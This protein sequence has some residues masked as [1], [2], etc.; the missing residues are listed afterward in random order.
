MNYNPLAPAVQDNP[1]PYYAELRD[2][3][4]VAWIESM[5]AWAVSR[6]ADV[7]FILR[8]PRLFSS[9][10][11]KT[12]SSGN[13]DVAPK[14][15]SLL[16]MDPPDHTRLRKL[17][18]KGFTPRL[19]RAMEPRVRAITQDLLETLTK[20]AEADL[21]PMLSVPLPII[22]IA[23]MLGVE[24]ERQADFKHWSDA[25]VRSLNRPTDKAIRAEIRQSMSE[26]HTYLGNMITRRRT[27]PSDDLITAFVQ[28]EEERQVLT[29][30]EILGLTVLLLAAGNETTTNLI[31]N[32]ALALLDHP[33]ELAKVRAEPASVPAMVEEVLR[34]DSPVQVVF[35]QTTQE[36]E[37]DGGTLPAGATILVLLGAANRDER[38]FPDPDRF[39]V[40]RNPQDHVGFGYGIHYC[41]G[42]PLARLESR[43]ALEALL[44]DC[45]PF[46]RVRAHVP[47]IAAYLVRGPQ[48]LPLRFETTRRTAA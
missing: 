39:E 5:Q 2:K 15:P 37:L 42:A 35:R 17:A 13:P 36:V 16:S 11:W 38:K 18:N 6:Y 3:A 10:S 47:R 34:Y 14:A 28:A 44:F 7:D 32:A 43:I 29:P 41:L 40:A 25:I 31:G 26:F 45:S 12:A 27:E 20:Q 33:E 30:I 1:Y 48:T 19:I 4:P 46:T 22:V 24:V 9:A 21:V 23:E 8:N